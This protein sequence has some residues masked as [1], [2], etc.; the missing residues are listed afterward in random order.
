[1]ARRRRWPGDIV[2]RSFFHRDAREVGPQLLN[3]LL[4]SDDGRAGR[5]VEVEAYVGAID[6]AAHTF[7]GKTRRNAVMFGPPGHMYVYFTY[8][9]HWCC[10]TVCG[11]EGE[12]SGVLI[13]ALEPVNGIERMRAARPRIR[14]DREL[15]SGPARLTQAM[16]ITGEQNGID[17]VAARDGYTILDDGTPPP[18]EVPGSARIGIREGTDLLWRWFVAGNVNVSRA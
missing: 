4:A 9:M 17:L 5:I 15:C 8:G 1:M 10:N 11:D 16:G 6:P 12:G 14:K 2:P 3:K 7:R 13:R 18:D